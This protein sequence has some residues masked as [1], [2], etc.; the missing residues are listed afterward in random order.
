MGSFF[1]GYPLV[2][3][4]GSAFRNRKTFKMYSHYQHLPSEGKTTLAVN[5]ALSFATAGEKTVLIDADLAETATSRG[6]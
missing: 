4:C 1:R 6:F 3:R 2:A 5:L